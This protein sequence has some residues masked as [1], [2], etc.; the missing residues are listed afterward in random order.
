MGLLC[1]YRIFRMPEIKSRDVVQ[2]M[3]KTVDRSVIAGQR[4]KDA[5][6]QAK[7]AA[8]ESVSSSERNS[9]EYAQNQIGKGAEHLGNLASQQLKSIASKE[10]MWEENPTGVGTAFLSV[11]NG[12][13]ALSAGVPTSAATSMQVFSQSSPGASMA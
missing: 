1:A 12:A 6:V 4:M 13:P 10:A 2:G 8:E 11:W 7:N 3:I 5:Y 9:N